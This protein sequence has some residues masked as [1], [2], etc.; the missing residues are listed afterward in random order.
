MDLLQ[1]IQAALERRPAS[2]PSAPPPAGSDE[3]VRGAA[4]LRILLAEDSEDN[5]VLIRSYLKGPGYQLE[6]AKD[7]EEA[8]RKFSD[9]RFEL[10]LMDMQMPVMDGYHA[11]EEIRARERERSLAPVPILALTAYA[12]QEEQERSMQAGCSAHLTKPIRQQTL[13]AAIR[14]YTA[15][16]V[17]VPERLRDIVPGYLERQRSGVRTLLD[18]SE[19]GDYETA[20]TFGHRMKGSGSG[21]GLDRITEIGAGIEQAARQRD[22][23]KLRE[24]AQALEDFLRRVA[25]EYE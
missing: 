6:I 24:L 3:A 9:G 23:G 11:T 1:A 20:A 15:I 22:A 14:K 17:R 12:L 21:Y 2:T 8:V 25:V 10:V 13:L 18:A 4:P 7:G 16:E 19:V 5:A